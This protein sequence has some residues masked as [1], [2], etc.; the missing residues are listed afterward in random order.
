[1]RVIRKFAPYFSD[2]IPQSENHGRVVRNIEEE[3]DRPTVKT[4]ISAWQAF[5]QFEERAIDY[6]WQIE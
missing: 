2:Q 4:F 3:A 1:L 6:R 5:W